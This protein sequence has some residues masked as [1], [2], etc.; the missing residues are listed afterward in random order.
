MET[1]QLLIL[2]FLFFEIYLTKELAY[3]DLM[4]LFE[5]DWL[6]IIKNKNLKKFFLYLLKVQVKFIKKFFFFK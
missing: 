3:P 4:Q 1:C 6:L 5:Q 2:Y